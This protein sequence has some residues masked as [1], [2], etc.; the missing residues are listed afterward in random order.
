MAPSVPKDG[1][2]RIGTGNLYERILHV[3]SE[4]LQGVHGRRHRFPLLH[5]Q[6]VGA[7]EYPVMVDR[8]QHELQRLPGKAGD[9]DVKVRVPLQHPVQKRQFLLFDLLCAAAVA[10]GM[11]QDHR[12]S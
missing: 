11:R 8:L 1:S 4:F 6:R 2:F 7:K 12:R 10:P 3:V 9:V 5:V